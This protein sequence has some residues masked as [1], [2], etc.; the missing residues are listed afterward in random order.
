MIINPDKCG[1]MCL[2]KNNYMI[3]NPDKA[4]NKDDDN[5]K[6]NVTNNDEKT[7]LRIEIDRN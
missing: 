2:G 5:L 1:N 7:N 6:S 4:K 3:I